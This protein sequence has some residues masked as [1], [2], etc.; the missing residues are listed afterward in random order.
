[1]TIVDTRRRPAELAAGGFALRPDH[2][3][4][5]APCWEWESVTAEPVAV[6]IATSAAI[7]CDILLCPRCCAAYAVPLAQRAPGPSAPTAPVL[8]IVPEALD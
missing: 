7:V 8:L 5:I 4:R 6:T 1:M 3:P 2:D